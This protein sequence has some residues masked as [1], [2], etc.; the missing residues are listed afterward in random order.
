M[1]SPCIAHD[2]NWKRTVTADGET[3]NGGKERPRRKGRTKRTWA[4]NGFNTSSALHSTREA[5]IVIFVQYQQFNIHALS[6]LRKARAINMWSWTFSPRAFHYF[7]LD[8]PLADACL[9]FIVTLKFR[10]QDRKWEIMSRASANGIWQLYP[11][12]A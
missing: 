10:I 4:S 11:S 3:E 5:I 1:G 7:S 8:F 6:R 12:D 2:L 9:M